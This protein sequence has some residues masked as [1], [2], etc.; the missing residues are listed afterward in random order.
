MIIAYLD[1]G[2]VLNEKLLLDMK[3]DIYRAKYLRCLH[4]VL[5]T[6]YYISHLDYLALTI[7][8]HQVLW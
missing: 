4:S 3:C 6:L 7:R 1:N 8:H 2:M 5:R